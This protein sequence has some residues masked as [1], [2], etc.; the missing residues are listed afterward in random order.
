MIGLNTD[1]LNYCVLTLV[2]KD[3]RK[4]DGNWMNWTAFMSTKSSILVRFDLRC[5]SLYLSDHVIVDF[6][7]IYRTLCLAMLHPPGHNVLV[8]AFCLLIWIMHIS[9][10]LASQRSSLGDIFVFDCLRQIFLFQMIIMKKIKKRSQL[11]WDITLE[12]GLLWLQLHI[13]HT[14]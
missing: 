1:I 4:P 13:S 3:L 6:C 12:Q 14:F 7:F 9:F 10:L 5:D 8:Q 2:V 11:L